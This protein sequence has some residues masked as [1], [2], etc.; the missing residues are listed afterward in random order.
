MQSSK[1]LSPSPTDLIDWLNADG[2]LDLDWD[3]PDDG[4]LFAAGLSS[5]AIL[6]L[7]VPAVE[8]K[9]GVIL[10]PEDLTRANLATP[11]SLAAVIA[12]KIP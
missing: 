2:V 6:H 7:L 10:G 8:D 4:D 9:Y 3:F 11:K 12:S 5:T 1:R